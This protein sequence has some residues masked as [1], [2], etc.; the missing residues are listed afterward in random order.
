MKETFKLVSAT[1]YVVQA[2][3]I[4]GLFEAL[5]KGLDEEVEAIV[6]ED[7]N[8]AQLGLEKLHEMLVAYSLDCSTEV[9]EAIT[10]LKEEIK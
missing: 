1:A 7:L 2:S 8:E 6:K 4:L 3:A 10:R 5:K 9:D